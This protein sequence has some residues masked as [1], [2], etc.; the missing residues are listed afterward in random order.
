MTHHDAQH[1]TAQHS[2]AQHSTAQPLFRPEVTL[3]L[4]QQSLG[5][6]RLAQPLSASLIAAVAVLVAAAL[7]AYLTLGSVSKK[8][9]VAGVTVPAGGSLSIAAPNAGV[10]L[11]SLVA[12]GQQVI[13]GQPLFV[14]STARVGEQGEITALV[15]QQL[16]SLEAE[17]RLRNS[18]YRDKKQALSLRLANLATEASQLEQ[19]ISLAQRR[20]S[21]ANDSLHKF[22][23]LQASGYV[24]SAQS[25]Q[26]QEELLD[27]AS[28]LSNLQRN[29][30]QLNANRLALQAEHAELGNSLA[31]E[32]AQLNRAL[33]SLQQEI[34]E[35]RN[36]KASLITAAQAGSITTIS[37]QPGQTV[38]G[39]QVLATLI[40]AAAR[41]QLEA[42]LYAPSRSAGFVATGQ[43]VLL[44]YQAYPYQKFGLQKG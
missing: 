15:A 9:R 25:Q 23:T 10:L 30:L 17:Q 36:R 16:A 22:Q 6:I 4:S 39:G 13:A 38:A 42:H 35:N 40:P 5:A 43:P 28:R 21:L 37:I 34:A 29:K 11:R 41:Q 1:S 2:T 44:R 12:E 31:A 26:K 3:A 20:L 33:A 14:L 19:E 8:A 18:Q 32:Q 7:I 27:L 24:S